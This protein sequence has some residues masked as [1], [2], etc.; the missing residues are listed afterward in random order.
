MRHPSHHHT[1]AISVPGG[2]WNDDH[3]VHVVAARLTSVEL[4]CSKHYELS[5]NSNK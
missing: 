3:A 2:N 1:C 4:E 5:N